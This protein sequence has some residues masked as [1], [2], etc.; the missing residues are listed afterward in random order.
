MA[1]YSY[2]K[3]NTFEN[4]PYQYRLNY[5]DRIRTGVENIEAFLGS[6]FHELMETIFREGRERQYFPE[7]L[8]ARF[9]ELWRAKWHDRIQIS[10]TDK[11][12]EDYLAYGEQ[13]VLNFYDSHLSPHRGFLGETVG[14]ELKIEFPLDPRGRNK[15]IG[16]IDRLS[17]CPDG[18]LEIQDYKTT[19]Q[20]PSE[21]ELAANR[22]LGIYQMGVTAALRREG[23]EIPP[24]RIVLYYVG[25]AKTFTLPARTE[26]EQ[27]RLA[28]EIQAL[29]TRIEGE[30]DF[31]ARVSNFCTWCAYQA[32]CPEYQK[33][34]KTNPAPSGLDPGLKPGLHP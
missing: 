24:L 31:P 23:R 8:Q 11:T 1:F 27:E 9:R 28:E 29:I 22:Q 33:Q 32:L 13:C 21:G 34:K 26:L 4:C 3:L 18:D 10:R 7:E 25:L 15:M 17:R 5:L 14:I 16:Y 12:A 30:R 19:P 2:S 6:C 20:L